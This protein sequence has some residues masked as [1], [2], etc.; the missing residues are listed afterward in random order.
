MRIQLACGHC[1]QRVKGAVRED[2]RTVITRWPEAKKL[3]G[4][5]GGRAGGRARVPIIFLYPRRTKRCEKGTEN[6]K[7]EVNARRR[8]GHPAFHKQTDTHTHTHRD[9]DT[10][11]HTHICPAFA[12]PSQCFYFFH[13]FLLV[14]HI[15]DTLFALFSAVTKENVMDA[16]PPAR[17]LAP[18][19]GRA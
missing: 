1:Q 14:L 12:W 13:L 9:T 8:P 17:P 3:R 10:H 7:I 16:R 4:F 6:I 19:G 2:H 15:F 11:T 5:P 18:A